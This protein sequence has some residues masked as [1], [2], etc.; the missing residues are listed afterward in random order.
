M[1]IVVHTFTLSMAALLALYL[2][3]PSTARAADTPAGGGGTAA[4]QKSGAPS[5]AQVNPEI[6]KQRQQ[7]EQ[8]AARTLVKEAI[9]AIQETQN[10]LKAIED[11]KADDAVA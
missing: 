3:H 5:Q 1:K 2:S 10:A 6:E 7:A 11:N 4:P 9:A 8:Q